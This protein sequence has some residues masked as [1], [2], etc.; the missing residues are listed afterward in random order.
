ML[1]YFGYPPLSGE[2]VKREKFTAGKILVES[3]NYVEIRQSLDSVQFI[4]EI[5]WVTGSSGFGGGAI[6]P[7]IRLES[8][9]FS[10]LLNLVGVEA[11]CS[12]AL[13]LERLPLHA[14]LL[15][16][17]LI[18]DQLAAIRLYLQV[19]SVRS[20]LKLACLELLALRLAY[21]A[22]DIAIVRIA[23][24]HIKFASRLSALDLSVRAESD[25]SHVQLI[26][27]L[28]ELCGL[29]PLVALGRQPFSFGRTLIRLADV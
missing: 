23:M 12:P 16:H 6:V 10:R 2:N 19:E 29:A 17:V 11:A 24:P 9:L 5:A 4:S 26:L 20:L 27:S 8:A 15:G 21:Q 3:L 28:S 14:K 18:A 1:F 25:K 22:L 13:S 7:R